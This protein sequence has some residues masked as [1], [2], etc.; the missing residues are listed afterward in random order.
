MKTELH[1]WIKS[2]SKDDFELM[3]KAYFNNLCTYS[4]RYLQ[5]EALA[6]D[7]VHDV[8]INIWDK[9]EKR[10]ELNINDA[11]LFVAIRNKSLNILRR[12]RKENTYY[13][14]LAVTYLDTV[15]LSGMDQLLFQE[16][17]NKID[18][19]IR[20]LPAKCREVFLLSRY[21][22]KKNAEIA[23]F[24]NISEKTVEAHITRALIVLRKE[25]E[26]YLVI[27]FTTFL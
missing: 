7:V 23:Q 10:L 9:R 26:M 5:D 1:K 20:E 4:Q 11:Y 17:E 2:G 14:A 8:F 18:K 6:V 22:G 12:L 24:L 27:F 21:E 13:E 15:T 3:Y 25:I 16:M 19:V